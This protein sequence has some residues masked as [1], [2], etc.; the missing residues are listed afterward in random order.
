MQIYYKSRPQ[1][2]ISE[3]FTK[4]GAFELDASEMSDCLSL[5]N[6]EIKPGEFKDDK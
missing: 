5:T 2:L 1:K 4:N 6:I 3:V